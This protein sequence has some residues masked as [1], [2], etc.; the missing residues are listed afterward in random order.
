[1]Y[2]NSPYHRTPAARKM[3]LVF[4]FTTRSDH[5]FEIRRIENVGL[6]LVRAA[7]FSSK[8]TIPAGCFFLLLQKATPGTTWKQVCFSSA[9]TTN[10]ASRRSQSVTYPS[11]SAHSII[12]RDKKGRT[13]TWLHLHTHI[14]PSVVG[15]L[16]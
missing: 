11:S 16:A 6:Q 12:K 4:F 15:P 10:P 14:R 9:T 7:S 3:N 5:F 1:M 8:E 2:P 13:P